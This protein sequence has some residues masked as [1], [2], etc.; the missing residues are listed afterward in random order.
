MQPTLQSIREQL[1]NPS[2]VTLPLLSTYD[3]NGD[4]GLHE[5]WVVK[6]SAE[7]QS[8]LVVSDRHGVFYLR[9][10]PRSLTAS[11]LERTGRSAT[12]S[13]TTCSHGR[14]RPSTCSIQLR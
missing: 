9:N 14:R 2:A 11:A 7:H 6:E 13:L 4:P 3:Q 5:L 8:L 1:M 12:L 10:D